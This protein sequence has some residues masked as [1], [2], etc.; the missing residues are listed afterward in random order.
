VERLKVWALS[1]SPRSAKK[2]KG[3]INKILILLTVIKIASAIF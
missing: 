1:S 3:Y 2:K